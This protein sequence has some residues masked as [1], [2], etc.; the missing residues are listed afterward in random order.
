MALSDEEKNVR[1]SSVTP[2]LEEMEG[3][4]CSGHPSRVSPAPGEETT[5]Q[6]VLSEENSGPWGGPALDQVYPEEPQPG[7]GPTLE[8]GTVLD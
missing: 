7:R 8:Q 3:R 1:S 2:R 6:Q 5:L 4:M